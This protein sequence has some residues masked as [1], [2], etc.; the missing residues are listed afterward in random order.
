MVVESAV[1][2]SSIAKFSQR[3]TR[4]EMFAGGIPS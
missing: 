1:E 3:Q 2:V 4:R